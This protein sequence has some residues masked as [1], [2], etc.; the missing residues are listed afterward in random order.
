MQNHTA[1]V[2]DRL[3]PQ[4][5]EAERALIGSALLQ[6]TVL[7][8]LTSLTAQ[9]FY[10]DAHQRLFRQLRAIH[11]A[12]QP[13]DAA[14][15]L[16]RL[17]QANELEAIGGPAYLAEVAH[18]VP[19]A[20]NA[21]YYADIVQ[22][23]AAARA[24]LHAG[25]DLIRRAHEPAADPSEVVDEAEEILAVAR[26]A[27]YES[28]PVPASRAAID[29]LSRI[30]TIQARQSA[31]GYLTGLADYDQTLGGLFPGELVVLAARP[32]LGKT[33]LGCQ[34]A[35][36]FAS[37]G[38]TVYFASLE[39]SAAELVNRV[40]CSQAGVSSKEIRTGQLTKENAAKLVEAAQPFHNLPW[41]IHDRPG[42]S[43]TEIRRWARRYRRHSLDLVVV[44]YLQR[45]T[46]LDRRVPRHEQIGAMT[47]P[48]KAM[49][50]ELE[51]PVLLLAQVNRDPE[52]D[53]RP[54]QLSDL[55]ASGDIEQDGDV[56]WLLWKRPVDRKQYAAGR[57]GDDAYNEAVRQ[58]A[59]PWQPQ[60]VELRVAKNRN[61]ETRRINLDW[62]PAETRFQSHSESGFE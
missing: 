49:A 6:P 8:D 37:R 45:L 18:S 39:M 47:G 26:T 56:V 52:R 43:V 13:I 50:R 16:D 55:K 48:L 15:L 62:I 9:H 2:F 4:D 58:L 28:A 3:P 53:A 23:K 1:D 29:A 38:R 7:D 30:D 24:V 32:G 5:L 36:H 41:Y 10:S 35:H 61:G 46:P 11:D 27:E 25:C 22:R 54:P 42:M 40:I 44:D 20:S 31:A 51:C 33:A 14:I 17:R 34:I 21:S 19:Y 12:G 60:L 57:L 59:N